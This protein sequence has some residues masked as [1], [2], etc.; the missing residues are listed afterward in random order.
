MHTQELTDQT[1]ALWESAVA[2]AKRQSKNK[3]INQNLTQ[4]PFD[5]LTVHVHVSGVGNQDWVPV[6]C[7]SVSTTKNSFLN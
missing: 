4:P 6:I 1:S 7:R 5:H 2:R 3:V